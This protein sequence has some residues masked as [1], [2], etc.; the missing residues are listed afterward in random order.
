MMGIMTKEEFR[1]I[2]I[3]TLCLVFCA[4]CLT[5]GHLRIVLAQEVK[6]SVKLLEPGE[7]IPEGTEITGGVIVIDD[8]IIYIDG[9]DV[10]IQ[11][12]EGESKAEEEMETPDE[13][14]ME[15]QENEQP[16]DNIPPEVQEMMEEDNISIK[17]LTDDAELRKRFREK[18]EKRMGEEGDEDFLPD[19]E[20]EE[21]E[22]RAVVGLERYTSVIVKKNL[23]RSLGSGGEVRGPSYALTAVISD[24]S[25]ESNSKAIIEQ[26]GGESYYLSEGDTFADEM[27]VIDI[28]DTS[29]KL[30]K[31]GEEMTLTLG[32]G[33]GGGRG[34]GG[35]RRGGGARRGGDPSRPDGGGG[36]RRDGRR[37][38]GGG[39]GF[40]A[41]RLP[42]FARKMLEDRGI[43]IE[44][45]QNN[46]ELQQ[47]LRR[48][49]RA[50][51]GDGAARQGRMEGARRMQRG[52]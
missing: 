10:E 42:P 13:R 24:S 11:I 44:E 2:R 14:N 45:L 15:S 40:D 19:E 46:P 52:R 27:E 35:G 9:L 29:V 6:V 37:G 50:M 28:E 31:S 25:G 49:F 21:G 30:D 12:D 4:L 18:V 36:G 43:S 17:D 41:S 22:G 3:L 8:D 39:G 1:R 5:P 38:G 33:T 20:P 7:T 48:E 16:G 47:E 26:Q 23:F 34:G 32:E 51:G